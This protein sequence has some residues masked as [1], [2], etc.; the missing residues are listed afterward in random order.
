MALCCGCA[1]ACLATVIGLNAHLGSLVHRLALKAILP[2]ELPTMFLF[3]WIGGSYVTLAI[4]TA[5]NCIF[6][7]IAALG[8][9][10]LLRRVFHSQ[11]FKRG[12]AV[13]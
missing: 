13:E 2:G 6:Y 7:S 12:D 11:M 5:L 10:H 1:I 9:M 8:S 4:V 3:A